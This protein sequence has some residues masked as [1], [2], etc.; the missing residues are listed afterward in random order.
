MQVLFDVRVGNISGGNRLLP[1][2]E[3]CA[4]GFAALPGWD[5]ATGLG[6]PDFTRLLRHMP[7]SPNGSMPFGFWERSSR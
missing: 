2:Y 6:S 3:D 1:K 5:A 4:E 7:L